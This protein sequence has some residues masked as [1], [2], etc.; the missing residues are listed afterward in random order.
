M[1]HYIKKYKEQEELELPNGANPVHSRGPKDTSC[2][3]YDDCLQ[4]ILQ[5]HAD[6]DY[7]SC[8]DCEKASK[9]IKAR[10]QANTRSADFD[11]CDIAPALKKR[12]KSKRNSGKRMGY[13]TIR[14]KN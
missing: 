2:E 1:G 5:A 11:I 8:V 7:F 3:L 9:S 4:Y 10:R 14:Q 6:W 13:K 12:V